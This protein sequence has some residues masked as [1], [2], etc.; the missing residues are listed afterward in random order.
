MSLPPPSQGR[1]ETACRAVVKQCFDKYGGTNYENFY[2]PYSGLF[3]AN[4][5]RAPDWFSL[6]E[7]TSGYEKV[8]GDDGRLVYKSECAKQLLDIDACSAP[9]MI[10]QAFGGFDILDDNGVVKYGLYGEEN[11]IMHRYLRPTGVATEVYNQIL[12]ILST[13]CM[14]LQGRFM[15]YQFF[16]DDLYDANNLCLARFNSNSKARYYEFVELY[17]IGNGE[18]LCPRDYSLGVATQSW[19][20]CICWENGA[21]RSKWGKSAKCVAALPK[22]DAKDAKCESNAELD[23]A[24]ADLTEDDWC[25]SNIISDLN[26]VCSV[27]METDETTGRC[28]SAGENV[29]VFGDLP[30]GIE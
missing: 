19:G 8:K 21:R 12:S 6:Y 3:D 30:E 17:K 28:K 4:S 23:Y 15:E 27:G 29:T 25:I 18:D 11:E 5:S 10:E 14:N 7:Y 1:V 9:E 13:Q 2:Y 24:T 20:A 26:Q 22:S 16:D